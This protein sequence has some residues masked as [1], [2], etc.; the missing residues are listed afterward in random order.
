M[1]SRIKEKETLV[2]YDMI[3]FRFEKA[4]VTATRDPRIGNMVSLM[5]SDSAVV[6]EAGDKRPYIELSEEDARKLAEFI[7][8][9]EE[10]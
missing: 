6:N 8:E 9:T 1:M 2:L 4:T 3:E 10:A 5:L 7:L